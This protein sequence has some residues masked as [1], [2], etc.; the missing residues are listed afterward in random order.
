MRL[1]AFGYPY[2]PSGENIAAG[3][4]TAQG[5]FDQW[6]NACDPDAW[7]ACTYAHRLNMLNRNY[8][9]I[10]VGRAYGSASTYGWY[11]TTD[12]GGYVDAVL[13]G[14]TPTPTPAPVPAIPAPLLSSIYVYPTVPAVGQTFMLWVLG[15]GF[16]AT[17]AQVVI[18]GPGCPSGC[19]INPGYAQATT[20]SVSASVSLRGTYTVGVRNGPTGALSSTQPLTV[21]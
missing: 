2:Y 1:A 15:S 20:L 8:M 12:F 21:Q 19:V 14:T 3:S 7:G 17:T 10:G 11:W 9:V 16:N 18:T 6:K 13:A 5:A 4:S